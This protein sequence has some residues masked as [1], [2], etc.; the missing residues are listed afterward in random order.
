MFNYASL[1]QQSVPVQRTKIMETKRALSGY[2]KSY[3]IELKPTVDPLVQLQN[4]SWQLVDYWI[5]NYMKCEG[6]KLRKL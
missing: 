4:T 2:T 5:L 6:T 1:K 3:E